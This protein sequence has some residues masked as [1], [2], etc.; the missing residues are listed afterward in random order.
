VQTVIKGEE[1]NLQGPIAVETGHRGRRRRGGSCFLR[2]ARGDRALPAVP[3]RGEPSVGVS[4]AAM[5]AIASLIGLRIC[6][7][8]WP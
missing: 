5:R 4:G 2:T 8:S 7:W 3:R 1:D 6:I